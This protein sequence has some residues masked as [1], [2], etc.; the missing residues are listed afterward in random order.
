MMQRKLFFLILAGGSILFLAMGTRQSFGLFLA[1]MSAELGWGRE[2]FS[3]AIAVQNLLWGLAQP[4]FGMIADKYGP[5]RLIAAGGVL[6]VIGLVLMATSTSA[7]QM[8]LGAG[9]FVGFALSASAFAVILGAVGQAAPPERRSTALGIT[10]M[11]GAVGQF[12]MVPG[13]QLLIGELGWSVSLLLLAA[14]AALIVPLAAAFARGR[15]ASEAAVEAEP[16]QSLREAVGEAARHGGFWYLSAGFFVCG[17]HVTF[18]MTHLPAFAAD[19]GLPG[20]TG[21]AALSLIGLFNIVG[22]LLFGALGDRYRKKYLL[23]ILYLLR[24][25]VIAGLL[26]A[27]L[28]PTTLLVFGGAMGVL[29]LATV[30]LTTGLVGEIFGV[31]YLTTLFSIVFLSH[32]VGAFLGVWLGGLAYDLTGS[33]DKVWLAA[34][35]LGVLAAALHWPIA[36]R[37]VPRLVGEG[38]AGT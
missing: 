26:V 30:P 6:Y 20:W 37:P 1:P 36:D 11:I 34:I 5:A 35:I 3:L 14:G 16:K 2:V 8:H 19:S 27:P 33:Y 4:F 15:G 31:R 7:W 32:Q 21:A 22:T 25:L 29:W 28:T 23:S 12:V 10:G 18:I 9:L 24:S 13:N 38:A 17:F